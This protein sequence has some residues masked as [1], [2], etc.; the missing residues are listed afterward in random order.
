MI[1]S[2]ELQVISRIL[3][4]EDTTE[5]DTLCAFDDSY[6][7][8][9]KPHIQFILDHRHRYNDVPDVFT[10]QVN[11][12]DV[13]LVQ[14][15]EPIEYLQVEMKKN[16]QH[17]LLLETFNKIKD[18]GTGDVSDAWTYLQMQCDKAAK[19]DD[20]KPMNIVKDAKARS[21]QVIQYSKQSRIPTG[22]PEIDKL[23][24]GGLS[25]VEELLVI[26]ARTNTGKSW[27]CSKMMESAQK[28][29]FPVGYYSPE[30]QAAFLATRFDTW[31]GHFQN[32]QLYRGNYNEEY[33]KYIQ[34]LSKDETDAF[35][36][37]DKDMPDGVSARALE[38]FVKKHGIK[39]LIID[40]I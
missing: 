26:L 34:E 14:V 25:T 37:E 12:P 16:K 3:T 9:F 1:T 36:I 4:T 21:E 11:F 23:M 7:S 38:P 18:L 19:L 6:Y 8:V 31:R 27:V 29:G 24:Y 35:V 2:I 20:V 32:S 5:V 10:F 28:H 13:T 30:M 40:G 22:F 15:D 39:L 17:I 33:Y